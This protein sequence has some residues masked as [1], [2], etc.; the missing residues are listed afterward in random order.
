MLIILPAAKNCSRAVL[1][2]EELKEKEK[3]VVASENIV[4]HTLG[5]QEN[6]FENVKPT[7][8]GDQVYINFLPCYLTVANSSMKFF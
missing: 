6:A 8:N 2:M 1:V 7:Y 5:S 4:N 3:E